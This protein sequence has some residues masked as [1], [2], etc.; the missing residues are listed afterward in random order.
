MILKFYGATEDVTGSNFLLERIDPKTGKK[1]QVLVDC[2]L[3]QGTHYSEKANFLAFPYEPKD[4]AAVFVTHAHI[5]HSGRLPQLYRKGFRG[6]VF[7]TGPTK[8]FV[9]ELLLDSEDILR[10]EAEREGTEILYDENDVTGLMTLWR[11][12]EYKRP[13]EHAGFRATFH[14]AGHILGSSSVILEAD[15]K[16]ILF[17][18]DI[19]N[20][21]PALIN[22][23]EEL[24]IPVDYCLIESTYGGRTH[25]TTADST[26]LLENI[27]ED[28]V[29][30]GGTLMIPAFA[31][32]RTQ[33]L[34]YEIND[35]MQNGRIPKVPIFI[36]SPLAIKL[37]DIYA[38]HRNYFT[39]EA[40]K[41]LG[42]GKKLFNFP[43]LKF[44]PTSDDSKKINDVKPPKVIIAGSGMSNGGRILHHEIRYLPDPK[45]TILFIGYQAMG[46]LGRR[47]LDGEKTV[48]I[49]GEEVP[50]RCRVVA[51]GGYSAHADQ[52][53]LIE[54]L[55][56]MNQSLKKV[57]IIHGEPD[58]SKALQMEIRDHLAIDAVVPALNQEIEL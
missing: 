46:T 29:H 1:I 32:E 21:S 9:R 49:F 6:A 15:G 22:R 30:A 2:G 38:R 35:L 3:H 28:T 40:D 36:D 13:V 26:E 33:R 12:A 27:I 47:I 16:S 24:N 18:G 11:E 14:N 8:D 57:F 25:E 55:R 17:S 20:Q 48:K 41:I 10:R 37:T 45:S 54:W 19:G 39:P 43:G 7:S 34:L 50:V 4:I 5:D 23:Y 31:M 51:I 52:G 42:A 53:G 58:E 44:T 56:P